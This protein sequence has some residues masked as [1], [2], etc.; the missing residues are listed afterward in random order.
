[1]SPDATRTEPFDDT[2]NGSKFQAANIDEQGRE[3]SKGLMQITNDS[4]TYVITN[5]V[6]TCW[7]FDC[8]RR[9][10]YIEEGQKLIFEV[11]RKCPTGQAIYAFRLFRARELVDQLDE[12]INLKHSQQT[13]QQKF[14]LT[15]PPMRA[16]RRKDASTST[17]VNILEPNEQSNVDLK[18]LSYVSIDFETTKALNDTAQAHAATR[19]K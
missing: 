9:Y 14:S 13:S 8:I 6:P 2:D 19:V 4:L 7:P 1:M 11:G 17:E 10:G 12:K 18:P 16:R 3:V 15:L 5:K